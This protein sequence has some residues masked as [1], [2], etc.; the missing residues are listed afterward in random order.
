MQTVTDG[1]NNLK[2]IFCVFFLLNFAVPMIAGLWDV[3]S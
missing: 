3:R 2:V 1:M